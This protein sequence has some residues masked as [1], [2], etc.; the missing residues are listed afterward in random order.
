MS[1]NN[2]DNERKTIQEM[3]MK[4]TRLSNTR[5]DVQVLLLLLVSNDS[6]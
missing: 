3:K 2:W 4:E 6:S 1:R 5:H